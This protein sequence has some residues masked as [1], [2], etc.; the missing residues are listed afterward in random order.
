MKPTSHLTAAAL[1]LGLAACTTLDYDLSTVPVPVSAKPEPSETAEITPFHLEEKHVMWVHGLAGTRQPDVAALLTEVAR[2]HDRIADLR[3]RVGA[4][5][6]DWFLTHLSLTLV[7]M[8]TVTLEG[9]LVRDR[10]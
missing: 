6:H 7:R 5:G 1:A 4:G 10:P 3:V 8:K 9:Q 2:G